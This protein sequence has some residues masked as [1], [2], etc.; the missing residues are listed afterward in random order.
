MAAR[1]VISTSDKKIAWYAPSTL[2]KS[3]ASTLGLKVQKDAKG[4]DAYPSDGASGKLPRVR[5]NF[6]NGKSALVFCDPKKMG[7]V[8]KQLAGKKAGGKTIK[9]ATF[10]GG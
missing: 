6:T 5:L 1:S 8:R 7:T 3:I 10:P 9:S 2:Y 4:L